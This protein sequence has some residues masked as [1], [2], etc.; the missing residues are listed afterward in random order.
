MYDSTDLFGKRYACHWGGAA[1]PS[2]QSEVSERIGGH[3]TDGIR[4][5]ASVGF[6]SFQVSLSSYRAGRAPYEV[7][8]GSPK[9][10]SL[11]WWLFFVFGAFQGRLSE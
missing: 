5:F 6:L 4:I 10:M 7:P 2:T 11:F 1:H 3:G 8:G 9:G